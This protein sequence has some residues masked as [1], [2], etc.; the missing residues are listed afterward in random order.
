MIAL[1][2]YI[3]LLS[4]LTCLLSINLSCFYISL[5]T[6]LGIKDEEKMKSGKNHTIEKM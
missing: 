1:P 3:F 4:L 6:K 5:I 2:F